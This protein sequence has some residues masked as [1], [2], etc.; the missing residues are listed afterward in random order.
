MWLASARYL[1][2]PI[3][4]T[5]QLSAQPLLDVEK[6]VLEATNQARGQHQG[7]PLV[8]DPVLSEIARGH[9]EEML[10]KGFFGHESPNQLCRKVADRLK[11]GYRFCLTSGENLHKCEGYSRGRLAKQAVQSWM[12][13][14][15]HRK[16]LLNSRFTRVGI[17]LAQKGN[18][19]VFTQVFS[20]EPILI[21]SL[22][23]TENGGQFVVK[24]AATVT[25]GPTTGGWFVDGKRRASWEAG[26]DG[27]FV[28]ELVL[29]GP[30]ILDVGQ[31][32]TRMN[33]SIET[34]IP[35]PPPVKHF[36]HGWVER[37]LAFLYPP[38]ER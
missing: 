6:E 30:G 17:G 15:T 28:T 23:V 11:F 21:D 34:T 37:L 31:A 5:A 13:S 16:N 35:I 33:W 26:P 14:S 7:K 27:K 29:N 4:L 20:Y 24:V 38:S 32:E 3:L 25:D 9:S 1:L 8:L 22:D 36:R 18:T 19:V 10:T 2:L 12:E